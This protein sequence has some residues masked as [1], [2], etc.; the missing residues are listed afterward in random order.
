M[1]DF[2]MT[3]FAFLGFGQDIPRAESQDA[4]FQY[5]CIVVVTGPGQSHLQCT[6]LP[7]PKEVIA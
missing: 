4:D 5:V 3:A 7:K 6:I 1:V 2:L